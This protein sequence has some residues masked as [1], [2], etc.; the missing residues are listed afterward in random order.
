MIINILLIV[1]YKL[2]R[3]NA[4]WECILK[5]ETCKPI[6]YFGFVYECDRSIKD[7]IIVT[8]QYPYTLWLRNLT[9]ILHY[10]LHYNMY[11]RKSMIPV[12]T[13]WLHCNYMSIITLRIQILILFDI[14]Y[15]VLIFPVLYQ[16][17]YKIMLL[18]SVYLELFTIEWKGCI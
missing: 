12:L 18:G 3:S 1:E 7:N 14:S 13:F 16:V 17:G 4:C 10:K 8:T 9:C 5:K 2:N 6:L 15:Y 11:H